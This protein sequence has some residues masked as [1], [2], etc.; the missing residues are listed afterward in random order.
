METEGATQQENTSLNFNYK[1][2]FWQGYSI[3][4]SNYL[5]TRENFSQLFYIFQ[6]L[7]VLYE[8]H[9]KGLFQICNYYKPPN[10]IDSNTSFH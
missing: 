6:R 10:K 5:K 9:S 1:D 7:S 4:Q 8:N 3:L 2:N